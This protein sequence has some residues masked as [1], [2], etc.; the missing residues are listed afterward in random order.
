M[1]IYI[2]TSYQ[3]LTGEKKSFIDESTCQNL[4][5]ENVKNGLHLSIFDRLRCQNL[6]G[7]NILLARKA[8]NGLKWLV[9]EFP[10]ISD[11][12]QIM[13]LCFHSQETEKGWLFLSDFQPT[14]KAGSQPPGTNLSGRFITRAIA[15]SPHCPRVY[16]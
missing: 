11:Q 4:T 16:K 5:G 6:K 14:Y 10:L 9:V 7:E 8:A 1:V 12:P 15:L 13:S 3:D 2:D